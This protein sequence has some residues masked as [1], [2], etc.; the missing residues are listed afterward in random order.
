[1]KQAHSSKKSNRWSRGV[2][3][4]ELAIITPFMALV[5]MGI[6]DLGLMAREH[7]VIQNAAR[8]GARYSSLHS[9]R[10][11]SDLNPGFTAANITSR[12]VAYCARE[13]VTVT[14][15]DV[16]VDQTKTVV[17][18]GLTLPASEVTA[19]KT[20]TFITPGMSNLLGT[21]TMEGVGLFRNLY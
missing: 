18:G 5:I 6:V 14:P 19:N 21:M 13:G 20:Y 2:I 11:D 4:V 3:A 9:S 1:M 15:A 17:V 8:E 16:G 10:I 12:V 7:Q